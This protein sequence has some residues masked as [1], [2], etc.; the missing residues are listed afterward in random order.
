MDANT[1]TAWSVLLIGL[2]IG[3]VGM[4]I[5]GLPGTIFIIAGILIH[6]WLLPDFFS[7]WIVNTVIFLSLFSAVV[8]LA[9][10]ALGAKLG[11]ATKFGLIGASLGALVGIPFGLPG[12]ILGPFFGA[13]AGD[14]YAKRANFFE[15]LKSG[16]GAALGFIVSLVARAVVLLSIAIVLLVGVLT[17]V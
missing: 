4:I 9:S 15:L 11:G 6:K 3:A 10:G 17:R 16:S 12:F 1:L 14:I 13:I 7:W 2:L 8:D 5:P